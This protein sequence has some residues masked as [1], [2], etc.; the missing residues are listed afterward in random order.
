MTNHAINTTLS[1]ADRTVSLGICLL[2]CL[3]FLGTGCDST[4]RV[5]ET[6]VPEAQ[7]RL[8]AI[9]LAYTTFLQQKGRPPANEKELRT[10]LISDNP[11][12]TLRSPRDGEPF[13]I[14][15]GVD[16][17]KPLDWA[18]TMPIL[19]Y[20]NRGEGTRWVLGIPGGVFE[21]EEAEFQQA[22]LPPGHK[23]D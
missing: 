21:L 14:C 9:N 1:N 13:V 11:D 12:E 22:D 2:I 16:L 20:E 8:M 3:A 23:V 6:E 19:A 15:Y 17:F 7:V 5:V 10:T 4:P 18:K